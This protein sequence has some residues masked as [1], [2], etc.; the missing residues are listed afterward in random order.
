[1]APL[2]QHIEEGPNTYED[3]QALALDDALSISIL[4]V[5]FSTL[6]T[7]CACPVAGLA[8]AIAVLLTYP[9]SDKLV[10]YTVTRVLKALS[11][12]QVVI[13]DAGTAVVGEVACCAFLGAAEEHLDAMGQGQNKIKFV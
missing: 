11:P 2:L 7:V 1:M 4:L 3:G 13:R 10:L 5:E 6:H 9:L 8:P 12:L